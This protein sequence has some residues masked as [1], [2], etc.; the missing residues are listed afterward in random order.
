V[1]GNSAGPPGMPRNSPSNCSVPAASSTSSRAGKPPGISPRWSPTSATDGTSDTRLFDLFFD[2][3]C[4]PPVDKYVLGGIRGVCIQ[5]LDVHAFPV[6]A[7]ADQHV[8]LP[9]SVAEAVRNVA[10][11]PGLESLQLAEEAP[12]ILRDSIDFRLTIAVRVVV[13]FAMRSILASSCR[14]FR[15]NCD[16]DVRAFRYTFS[17]CF[18]VL[19]E[20]RNLNL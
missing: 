1:Q 6:I 16:F 2:A 20:L 10:N 8:E 15:R 3:W 17:I 18:V 14:E 7:D 4:H 11:V 12:Q 9:I 5:A 13:R 19:E